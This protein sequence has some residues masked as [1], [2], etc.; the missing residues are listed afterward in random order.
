M[1]IFNILNNSVPLY[2]IVYFRNYFLANDSTKPEVEKK[3]C[4][5]NSLGEEKC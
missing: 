3:D 4:S 1:M 2:N 5:K